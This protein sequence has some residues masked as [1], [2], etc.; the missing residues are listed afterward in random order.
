V[1]HAVSKQ[2]AVSPVLALGAVVSHTPPAVVH[3]VSLWLADAD[4]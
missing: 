3:A 4:P 1:Q 2:H